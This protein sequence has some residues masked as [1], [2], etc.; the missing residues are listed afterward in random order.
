M[1]GRQKTTLFGN[2]K[3]QEDIREQ[4]KSGRKGRK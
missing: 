2:P 3:S 4:G 1:G